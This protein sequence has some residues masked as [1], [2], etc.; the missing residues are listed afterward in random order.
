MRPTR[1]G[2]KETESAG[3]GIGWIGWVGWDGAGKGESV[4]V[5]DEGLEEVGEEE[6]KEKKERRGLGVSGW[7]NV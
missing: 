5:G 4:V 2:E 1:R 3:K 6:R 7:E